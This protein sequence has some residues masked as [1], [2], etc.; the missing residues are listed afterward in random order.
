MIK[1]LRRHFILITLISI[2]LV[3][4]VMM[5][6]INIENYH[7][8]NIRADEK[9]SVIAD[10]DGTFPK[11]NG[12]N[13]YK[14]FDYKMLEKKMTAEAP[15]DTRY[16]TVKVTDKNTIVS[17][18]TGM[19]AAVST[20]KAI[21]YT[22]QLTEKNKTSGFIDNYKYNCVDTDDGKMY[23][24]LDCERELSTFYNFLVVSI[25][26][27]VG[28]IIL[29]Y[30]LVLVF[31]KIVF[32]PVAESYEKQK[33]FITDASHE[34]KTPLTIIDAST[35]II[36]MENGE[37]EWTESIKNQVKRL[38]ALTEKLV[39]L[40]RMDEEGTRLTMLDFSISDA[41]YEVTQGFQSVA[42][43]QGKTLT[44]DIEKDLSYCGDESTIRQLVSLLLDNAMK[45]SDENGK[46]TVSLKSNGKSRV[47]TVTNSVDKIEKGKH[48]E[49]FERFYRAD[50]SRNSETGGHGIGLSVVKAIANAH[51]GKAACY[52]NDENSI[53]FK[54]TL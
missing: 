31:S 26:A 39:F 23:I 32:K 14:P 6:A 41:V 50:S 51:K 16:F 4:G 46:I 25:L 7:S 21:N 2:A 10:N 1:K 42:N 28:G 49:L 34:I 38:T 24:F 47:I 29:V 8:V 52:S 11:K 36:E 33:Q 9:I 5:S 45:Y 3:L 43:S 27:S 53:T 18:N 44:A 40:S 15:F 19:I 54:I 37:N 35:E 30:L 22:N 17:V 48:D 20:E 13:E 12:E